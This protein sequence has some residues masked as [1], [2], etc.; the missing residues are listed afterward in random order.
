MH[1]NQNFA[2]DD[3]AAVPHLADDRWR[4]SDDAAEGG[5]TSDT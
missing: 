4:K 2:A 1:L 3:Q 5:V